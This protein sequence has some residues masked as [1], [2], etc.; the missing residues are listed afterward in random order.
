M[1][2]W[3]DNRLTITTDKDTAEK[4]KAQLSKPFKRME[5]DY[6]TDTRKEVLVEPVM[7]FLN[8][9]A[10]P[11]DKMDLYDEVHGSRPNPVTGEMERTG[12]TEWNWYNFNNREWGTKWDIN[13]DLQ[14]VPAGNEITLIYTFNTAWSPPTPAIRVLSTQYPEVEMTLWYCEEQG[15]GGEELFLD[16][17]AE[18]LD[19][20]D[21]PNSHDEAVKVFG[22]CY[23]AQADDPSDLPYTDCAVLV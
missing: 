21:I 4:I 14:E 17:S 18:T 9:V 23:C 16:G 15:F 5:T 12:D 10:P 2:N 11:A 19:E 7:S 6:A 20:W 8:I 13:A 3:V 22:E 1:P